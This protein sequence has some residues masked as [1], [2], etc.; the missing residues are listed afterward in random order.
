M[1]PHPTPDQDPYARLGTKKSQCLGPLTY[2]KEE[3]DVYSS[4]FSGR[5]E[6]RLEYS[7]ED[8]SRYKSRG[9]ETWAKNCA[10]T[11]PD[12]EEGGRSRATSCLHRTTKEKLLMAKS[13]SQYDNTKWKKSWASLLEVICW[14]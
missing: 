9:V 1:E 12:S 5:G 6:A 2:E 3:V 13:P 7:H 11:G 8:T 14:V 10:L 4:P